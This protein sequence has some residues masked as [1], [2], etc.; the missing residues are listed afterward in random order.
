MNVVDLVLVERM[1]FVVI[2][3]ETTRAHVKPA[4]LGIHSMVYVIPFVCNVFVSL[5]L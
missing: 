2:I 4:T 5:L 1:Q 3:L